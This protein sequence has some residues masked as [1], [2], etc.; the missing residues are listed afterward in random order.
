MAKLRSGPPGKTRTRQHVI[1]DLSVNHVE[2]QVLLAGHAIQR[3]QSD[4]GYDLLMFTYNEQ[5][6]VEPGMVF[7]QAKATDYLPRLS[8]RRWNDGQGLLAGRASLLR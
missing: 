6:E 3:V 1:A 8:D 4:Y 2:R 7:F 5:G